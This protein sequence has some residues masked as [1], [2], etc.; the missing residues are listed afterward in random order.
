[1]SKSRL[2]SGKQKKKSGA[3]LDQDR[4]DYLDV[5]NAEPDLG[6][7][8]V[9]S[10]VLIG[11]IDGTR[12]WTDITTYAND[13]RGYTGSQGDIGYTGSVG[14]AGSQG[15]IGYTGSQGDIGY[16]G[17][18]G[19]IGYTGSQGD[20]GYTGSQGDI[21]YTGSFGFTGSQGPQGNFG[22]VTFDYTF[23]SDITDSAPGTGKLKLNQNNIST[24]SVLYIQD[25]DDN[26]ANLDAYLTTIDASTSQLKGHI[27]ISNKSNSDDFA[28]FAITNNS[29][30][31]G[32]YFSVP[33]SYV[34][35]TA[36]SFSNNEDIIITFARTGDKGDIGYTG[37]QGDIGYTGSVGFVGSQG[38]TGS[39]GDIGYTGSQGDVGYTGSF[40]FT[41]SQ[42][43]IGYTGSQG[44]IGYTGSQGDIG[45]T[46]SQGDIGYTGSQGDVGYTGSFGFTG[47]QGDIGYTG[48][49][50]DIGYTGSQG[51]IGF[52]GSQ[53]DI[54]F[55]GSQGDIGY[56][57][58][59]GDIGYTGSASTE[60]GY[61]G[62]VGYT[63]SQGDI[64]YTGSQGDIGYTG[65]QGDIGYTGS[66]VPGMV[67]DGSNT[68]TIG[69][70]YSIVPLTDGLQSLGSPTAA[71]GEIYLSGNSIYL[72]GNVI[73]INVDGSLDIT[74]SAGDPIPVRAKNFYIGSVG[75]P[76][77]TDGTSITGLVF[78]DGSLQ[79]S[80][81][82]KMYTNADAANG[83]SLSDLKPGD[84]YYD[85]V[86]ASIYICYDTG[87]GY[88][89]IL[90]L[91]VRS[92]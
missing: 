65:S 50:G 46:G 1:M 23:D 47:S 2:V 60:I 69:T 26:N 49:Q 59:Q 73:S 77:Y 38:Y 13:F 8:Q 10:S 5:S 61:T 44:D 17:S 71:W 57:G 3:S 9:D 80:A 48:S 14:F 88:F 6:L 91:T 11:D 20:I 40:G 63:G 16:T 52:T 34:S 22:G 41:G 27:R 21:G 83:L 92:S 75:M 89:D 67:S 28:I 64:G 4:Y 33:V 32:A 90:D 56:T 70:G 35:G 43:D 37:S 84:Y 7:P 81:A 54:G 62:S 74:D 68:I 24:A 31:N 78:P 82:S 18:Q 53:G 36:S 85:D 45:Y 58:S 19:D 15:D 39:Q 25:T 55:T 30:N 76:A 29:T 51:D 86:N 72:G 12:T 79:T 87:L 42:G 66:A